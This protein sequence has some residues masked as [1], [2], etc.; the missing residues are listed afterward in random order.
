LFEHFKLRVC[1][2]QTK[3]QK[4]KCRRWKRKKIES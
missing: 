2:F 4:Y 1:K 3:I